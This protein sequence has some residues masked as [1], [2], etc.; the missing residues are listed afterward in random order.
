[1]VS[2]KSFKTKA[3]KYMQEES[4]KNNASESDEEPSNN[5]GASKVKRKTERRAQGKYPIRTRSTVNHGQT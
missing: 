4:K 3:N 1:M 2:H 5:S